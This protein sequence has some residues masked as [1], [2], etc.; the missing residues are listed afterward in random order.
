MARRRLPVNTRTMISRKKL[1]SR[2]SDDG[3]I[4]LERLEA[5]LR[6]HVSCF[7]QHVQFQQQSRINL[8]AGKCPLVTVNRLGDVVLDAVCGPT[9]IAMH[10]GQR[11]IQ[12]ARLFPVLHGHLRLQVE[13]QVAQVILGP[14]I[15]RIDGERRLEHIE[16]LEAERKAVVGRHAGCVPV[17]GFR[18]RQCS[19]FARRDNPGSSEPADRRLPAAARTEPAAGARRSPRP[20]CRRACNRWP[21]PGTTGRRRA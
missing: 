2:C 15:V 19:P 16:C 8:L 13:Q 4:G 17:T 7:V 5:S 3:V 11:V 21:V 9:G 6:C 12:V 18:C 14:S 10:D 20:T 1:S